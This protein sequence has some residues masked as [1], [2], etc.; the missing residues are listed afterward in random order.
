MI[1]APALEL[2]KQT[3]R[4]ATATVGHAT[5]PLRMSPD[6]LIV[7]AQ[8]C[9]TTSLFRQLAAHP[10]VVPPLFQKG[11]HFFDMHYGR[12]LRW[13][14]GHFPVR[15]LAPRRVA[16]AGARPV[17]GEASPYYVFHPLAPRRIARDLPGVKL[18]VLLRDPVERAFSAHRQETARGFETEPFERALELE[19]SRLAGEVEKILADPMYVSFSHQHHAYVT[20]G[21]YAEQLTLLFELFGRERVLVLESADFFE[22]PM[23]VWERVLAFL[24]LPT[25]HPDAFGRHNAQPRPRLPDRLRARL[26]D[27]FVPH[28]E[29]LAALLGEVPTWRR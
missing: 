21:H 7:G 11:I 9:G 29:R 4:T 20:R 8:R 19:P 6:F 26:E 25:W 27:Y 2:A 28:D 14:R 23:L 15:S 13:Y 18:I 24:G 5:A 17:T 1:D 22:R 3:V 12:G 16:R 10:A